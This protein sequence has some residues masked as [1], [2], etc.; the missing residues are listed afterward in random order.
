MKQTITF[1]LTVVL[2]SACETQTKIIQTKMDEINGQWEIKSFAPVNATPN[3]PIEL[4]KSGTIVFKSCRAKNMKITNSFCRGEF[5]MNG[6]IYVLL[7]RLETN[8]TF[9]TFPVTT[10]GTGN[11]IFTAVNRAHK[12]LLDGKWELTV[13]DNTMVG[14]QIDN[15]IKAKPLS[16]FTATRK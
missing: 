12:E 10:D 1:I 5:E 8:F 16:T 2:L 6:E 4:L 9:D 7:Y 14:K 11:V 13:T 3:Q 15:F